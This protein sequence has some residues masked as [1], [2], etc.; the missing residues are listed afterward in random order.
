[1]KNMSIL[2]GT[3]VMALV[4]LATCSASGQQAI[5]STSS[6]VKAGPG[7]T[8][9]D[10]EIIVYQGD[11]V[12]GGKR[13]RL[14]ELLAQG[15]PVVLNFWAG[16]CPPCRVEM[17]EFQRVYDRYKG[18]IILVGVDV[19]PFTF[20][21]TK[22]QG[23]ALIA[24]LGVTYPAATTLDPEV[25]RSYQV[26]GMPSTYFIT[27]AGEIVDTWTGLLNEEKL[28]ELVEELLEVSSRR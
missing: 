28:G 15:K 18:R 6:A 23:Q 10:F 26:L 27:P 21:G 12:L 11:D 24:E 22:E 20:L 7:R 5:A 2:L 9:P 3:T 13:L 1:M 4:T 14:S 19:G 25:M 17:P 16:L 8:A